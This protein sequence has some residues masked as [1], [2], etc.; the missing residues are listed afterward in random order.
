MAA[1]EMPD[2]AAMLPPTA[3][4][5]AARAMQRSH[6]AL[7]EHA[8]L[9]AALCNP[10]AWPHPVDTVQVLETH[11]STVL[12]AGPHACKLKKPVSLGFADFST[13]ALRRHCCNEELR[14]NRRTAPALYLG[15]CEVAGPR[16]RPRML[17]V[18]VA[19]GSSG[20]EVALCMRRFDQDALLDHLARAGRLEAGH[21]DRLA[22]GLLRFHA[23]A[24]A[25]PADTPFGS[26]AL[27]Q[28]WT[29]ASLVALRRHLHDGAERARLHAV[30][31]A[32]Q[33]EFERR[34]AAIGLRRLHG[35]VRECH[36]DLHL[37]NL[38]LVDGEPLP[39]DA[40]EFNDELRWID[41][42]S[43]VAFVF[44]DLLAHGLPRLAWRLL[45]RWLQ[46]CGDDGGLALLRYYAAY[47]ALVRAQVA[48]IR[49]QQQGGNGT[50]HASLAG[51]L[52]LAQRLL[53]SA[54]PV[55]VAMSGL[56]GSGKSVV[57]Q[58]LA[59][60]LG[61]VCVR[62]DVERKRLFGLP[63]TARVP[64]AE[65]YGAAA[66]RRTYER[67]HQVVRS[68]IDAR[69]PVV[70]DAASLRRHE[71]HAMRE[72]AESLDVRFHLVVC[73]APLPLLRR[74]VAERSA[75]GTDASD[76]DAAVLEQQLQWREPIAADEQ[77]VAVVLETDTGLDR[78]DAACG[79]L[80]ARM[81]AGMTVA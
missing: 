11:I 50:H 38:V 16:E 44:M 56:S 71:R 3:S 14:I 15:L 57:A 70:V 45:G 12:L 21:M 20:I 61:G 30:D 7:R 64:A 2:P 24:A 23:Q 81:G 36:G 72:L 53:E 67:L 47:R 41:V 73:D 8:A 68:C 1:R 31:A 25:A 75:Q 62:S 55:V 58:S 13:P 34:A 29:Q 28:R 66:G 78:L 77:P 51:H 43:D 69:V 4:E 6:D 42:V 60:Q 63:A 48:A 35:R 40:I 18:G 76:A 80:A 5:D 39:F 9:V 49:E 27:V 33:A 52:Q 46:G 19:A 32:L 37:G 17:P 79:D 65:I 54:A 10:A 74:R 22:A 59:E 26:A